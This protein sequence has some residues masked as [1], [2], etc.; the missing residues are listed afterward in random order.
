MAEPK[1]DGVV[2]TGSYGTAVIVETCEKCGFPINGYHMVL[3][4]DGKIDTVFCMDG[5]GTLR[6]DS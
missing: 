3:R 4:I 5:T 1:D 2:V 6:E